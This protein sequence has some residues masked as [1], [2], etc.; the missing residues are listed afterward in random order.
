MPNWA[1]Y[2]KVNPLNQKVN[3]GIIHYPLRGTDQRDRAAGVSPLV[4]FF[5]IN[6]HYCPSCP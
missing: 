2:W 6:I 5:Y 3:L 4:Y 1:G